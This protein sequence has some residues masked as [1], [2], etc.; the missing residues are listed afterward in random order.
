M[1]YLHS[2]NQVFYLLVTT[3]SVSKENIPKQSKIEESNDLARIKTIA[4]FISNN[5]NSVKSDKSTQL[6]N[7]NSQIK[8]F[9]GVKL[10]PLDLSKYDLKR[11]G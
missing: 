7:N 9:S 1:N 3:C 11:L 5:L 2:I 10:V 6:A 8:L 4:K